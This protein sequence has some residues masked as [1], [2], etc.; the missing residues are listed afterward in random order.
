MGA[1][2]DLTTLEQC[3]F[4]PRGCRN[5]GLPRRRGEASRRAVSRQLVN[6]WARPLASGG[7]SSLRTKRLGRSPA[8]D[9]TKRA[10]SSSAC[11][12]KGALTKG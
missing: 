2:R 6:L 12:S 3:D 9:A 5:A 4:A 10:R 8:L 11:S 1:R 7:E